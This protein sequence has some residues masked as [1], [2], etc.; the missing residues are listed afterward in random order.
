MIKYKTSPRVCTLNQANNSWLSV[1]VQKK[2]GLWKLDAV[3]QGILDF[4]SF[5]LFSVRIT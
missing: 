5:S 1:G 2:Y 4:Y 3:L